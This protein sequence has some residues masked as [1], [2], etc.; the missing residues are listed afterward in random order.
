[1]TT[2]ATTMLTFVSPDFLCRVVIIV[3]M[4]LPYDIREAILCVVEELEE[5]VL[6][7]LRRETC[8]LRNSG[9]R[10]VGRRHG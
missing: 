3:W 10:R 8:C 4:E 9:R 5:V 2:T 6:P 1:M 7:C